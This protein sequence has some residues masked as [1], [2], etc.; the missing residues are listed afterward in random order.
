M[1]RNDKKDLI[2]DLSQALAKAATLVTSN[3]K[4]MSAVPNLLL[5]DWLIPS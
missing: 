1:P 3:G 2:A 5:E 4:H